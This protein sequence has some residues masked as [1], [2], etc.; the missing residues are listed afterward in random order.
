MSVSD[1]A[2]WFNSNR[3]F[4]ANQYNGQWV[5]VKDQKIQGAYPDYASAYQA[6][7]QM[8][9]PNSGF[10]VEQALAQAPVHKVSL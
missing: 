5:L 3:A 4:I 9:G 8:F 1:E 7:V 10:L 6:G 2:S